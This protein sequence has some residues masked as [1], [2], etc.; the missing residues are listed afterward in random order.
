M[1]SGPLKKRIAGVL[2]MALGVGA[3][4][5]PLT[6]GRWS[7]A[8]LGI[9]VMVLSV[10]EAYAAFRSPQR[11]K[12]GAYLP[13]VL[14][15]LAGNLLILS[16]ALLLSGLQVVLV[17]IL[18]IDG[19]RLAALP[20]A[21]SRFSF[22]MRLREARVSLSGALILLLRLGLPVTAF[23]VAFNPIWGFNWYFNTESWATGVYQKMTE[24]RVNSW[25][26]QHD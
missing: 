16:S 17:A 15:P 2:L 12:I 26:V 4:S 1:L 18:V 23:F 8:A 20:L 21:A 5:A 9:P 14:A 22:D 19:G 6:V 10:A 25:R 24:L 13:S 3:L 11:D 7:L